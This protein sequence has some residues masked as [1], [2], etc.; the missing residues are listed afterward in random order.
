MQSIRLDMQILSFVVT[1]IAAF[2]ALGLFAFG[3][4]QKQFKGFTFLTIAAA[5][6]ATGFFLSGYRNVLPDF[7]TI[8]LADTLKIAAIALFYEGARRFLDRSDRF[9]P[10]TFA[11]IAAGMIL[12][13]YFTY[14]RPSESTRMII[15]SAIQL[16]ISAICTWELS[17]NVH[18][19][20]RLP[21]RATAL[22][23]AVYGLF[24]LFRL[25]W[26][27]G[28]S[29]I[30][31][32]IPAEAVHIF[33]IIACIFLMI[34]SSF[35]FFW[36]VA[37]RLSYGQKELAVN[38]PVTGVLNRRGLEFLASQEFARRRRAAIDLSTVMID[39][40]GFKKVNDQYGDCAGDTLLM[41]FANLI[42]NHLRAFDIF[43]R[44][45]SDEFLVF[46]PSTNLEQAMAFAERF[47][48]L[49]EDRAFVV[50]KEAIHITASFGVSDSFPE[51]ATLDKLIQLTE[52]ALAQS[53]QKGRNC[54]SSVSL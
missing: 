5:F 31:S 1:A 46:L 4:T 53:K 9:H 25:L 48:K 44:I 39:I 7:L 3:I 37:Q 28:E 32:G 38:D 30:H 26:T 17:R 29:P 40:D 12:L 13:V 2:Y 43:G 15:Y 35:G 24:H 36:M 8:V 47:R 6:F 27:P 19:S 14:G 49:V 23:F 52:K 42:Q 20:W 21:A 18:I 54:V 51:D 34:G 45:G 33:S 41:E 22:V 11:A 50:D 16:I 10:V